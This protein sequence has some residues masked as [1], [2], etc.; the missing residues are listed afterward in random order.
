M[1]VLFPANS[2]SVAV[3]SYVVSPTLTPAKMP[4]VSLVSLNC[5]S[6]EGVSPLTYVLLN[7]ITLMSSATVILSPSFETVTLPVVSALVDTT[8]PF[9]TLNVNA[10]T[11]V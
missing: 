4:S 10:D 1:K 5:A 7:S 6:S 2:I 11:T 9:S 3:S 8:T